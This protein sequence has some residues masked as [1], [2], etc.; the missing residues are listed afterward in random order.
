MDALTFGVLL[1]T[2]LLS[3][4]AVYWTDRDGRRIETL[5]AQNDI[6]SGIAHDLVNNAKI[7]DAR[8]QAMEDWLK[9][10]ESSVFMDAL[11]RHTEANDVAR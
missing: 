5:E 7:N 3:V 10:D 8:Q 11:I 2:V 6:L 1:F 9:A 4:V